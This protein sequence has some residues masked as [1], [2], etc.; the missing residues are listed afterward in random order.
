MIITAGGVLSQ[1]II[2]PSWIPLGW[3]GFV[4]GLLLVYGLGLIAFL[5]TFGLIPLRN[6]VRRSRLAGQ[7]TLRW[8]GVFGFLGFVLAFISLTVLLVLEPARTEELL[9]RQNPVIQAATSDP[10]FYILFSILF[11]GFVEETLFRGYV[12][13]SVLHLDGTRRWPLHVLWTSVLFGAVHLYYAQT[14]FEVSVVYYVQ[15]VTLAMAFSYIYVY[16]GGNILL[17]ALLHGVFD[18]L[19]FLSLAPGFYNVSA[20]G[21]YILLF[22]CA[23]VAL[24]LYL[25]D[26]HW[27]VASWDGRKEVPAGAWPPTPPPAPWAAPNNPSPPP[28]I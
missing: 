22:G 10:L 6:Y 1:Y 3:S 18:A 11:V 27:P 16:S 23:F 21:R 19:S 8:Y 28:L 15:L 5:A 4:F 17:P 24:G 7:E 2:P 20:A 25:K 26:G 12:L 9:S 13:G 14:Y